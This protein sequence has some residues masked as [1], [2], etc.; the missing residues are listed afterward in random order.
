M[1]ST[2]EPTASFSAMAGEE[3]LSGESVAASWVVASWVV[4]LAM[5]EAKHSKGA[6]NVLRVED[7]LRNGGSSG[8]R[9]LIRKKEGKGVLFEENQWHV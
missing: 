1:V 5:G 6:R 3:E 4:M 9:R 8:S 7:L 2:W